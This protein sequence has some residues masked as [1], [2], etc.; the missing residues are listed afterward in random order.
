ML[1]PAI[2]KKKKF[3]E[4][5]KGK[6]EGKECEYDVKGSSIYNRFRLDSTK[7]LFISLYCQGN[8][9]K[10]ERRRLRK[11][12]KPVSEKLLPNGEYLS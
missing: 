2:I 9:E 6:M 11:Q 4:E 3:D 1:S 10:C 12:G 5:G 8:F 7:D